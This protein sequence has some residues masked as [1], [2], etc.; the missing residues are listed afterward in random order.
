MKWGRATQSRK[1]SDVIDAIV[2]TVFTVIDI[3]SLPFIVTSMVKIPARVAAETDVKL[4][5]KKA[6]TSAS[7]P[8]AKE[9]G[10]VLLKSGAVT[11]AKVAKSGVAK[12]VKNL[13]KDK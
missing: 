4:T 10:N 6:F 11:A 5:I 13:D 7:V 2:A 1:R 8:L 3:A 9:F 12:L